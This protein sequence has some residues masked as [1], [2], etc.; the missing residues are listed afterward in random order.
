MNV[1]TI[2]IVLSAVVLAL[3][4]GLQG[5]GAQSPGGE[6]NMRV[7]LLGTQAGPTFNAQRLGI[8][9]L[10]LAGSERLLFDAGRG[11]TTGMARVAESGRRNESIPDPSPFRPCHLAART[12]DIAMGIPRP[13]GATPGVGPKWNPLDDAEVSGGIGF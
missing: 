1:R 6:Q 3:P 7:I 9:T 4:A 13:T 12:L 2:A 10:V 11:T 8:S 5:Q